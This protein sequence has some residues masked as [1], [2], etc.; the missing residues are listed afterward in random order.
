MD[1]AELLRQITAIAKSLAGIEKQ[2]APLSKLLTSMEID[3]E[4]ERRVKA[5]EC[6]D[7]V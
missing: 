7:K 2:L 4:V 5:H 6:G 1:D 3:R